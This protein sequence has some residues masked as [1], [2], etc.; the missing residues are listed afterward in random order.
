M[1]KTDQRTRLTRMLLRKAL[2]ELMQQKPI[3]SITIKELCSAAGI[4]RGTFY[5]HHTDIYD[6]LHQMEEDLLENLR[7]AL[8]PLLE[9]SDG[10][11]KPTQITAGIFQCIQE[12]ADLCSV[13]LGP[14]G[15]K[16]FA[17]RLL[18]MGRDKCVESYTKYFEGASRKQIEYYY[19]FV[20]AGCVGLLEKWLSDGMT[21]SAEKIAQIAENIMLSGIHSLKKSEL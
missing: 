20:S 12:N 11:L 6:L 18:D 16:K 3:Q 1:Q 21:V 10:D 7:T 9:G 2:T 17:L 5:A 19:A 14:Y 8:Q 13:T 4:N 15:D